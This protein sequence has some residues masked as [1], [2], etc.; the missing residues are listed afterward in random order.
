[1]ERGERVGGFLFDGDRRRKSFD[2]VDFG[3]LHLVEKLPRIGGERLDVAALPFSING[4]K[5]SEDF[6]EPERPVITVR[7]FR[8]I[9][10]ADIFEVVLARATDYQFGQA[11]EMKTLPPQEPRRPVGTL[12]PR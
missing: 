5:A 8:G 7:L 12:S 3:A 4:V 2:H 1:V 9:S 11:H 6:P 10:D